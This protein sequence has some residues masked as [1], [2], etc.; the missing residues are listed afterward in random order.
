MIECVVSLIESLPRP[1]RATYLLPCLDCGFSEVICVNECVSILKESL[2][3]PARAT[4][5]LPVGKKIPLF[6]ERY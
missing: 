5:L 1:A 3:R 6:L 4:Y 2:P